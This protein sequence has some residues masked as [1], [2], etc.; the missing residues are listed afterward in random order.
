MRAPVVFRSSKGG[1]MLIAGLIPTGRSLLTGPWTLVFLIGLLERL[2]DALPDGFAGFH[3]KL[4]G[5]L[6]QFPVLG[7]CVVET[8][9]RP[10]GGQGDHVAHRFATQEV[11]E[12]IDRRSG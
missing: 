5:K 4:V 9:A 11:R 12:E 1:T 3:R 6:P 2:G 7:R 8:L 10:R